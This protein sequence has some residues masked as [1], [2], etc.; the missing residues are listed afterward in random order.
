MKQVR[1][2]LNKLMNY[3]DSYLAAKEDATMR[4]LYT[5]LCEI[6]DAANAIIK[7]RNTRK[8]N[9]E[10]ETGIEPTN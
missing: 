3:L 8:K 10:K 1:V 6:I 5:E 9:G 4:T 2:N 7:G